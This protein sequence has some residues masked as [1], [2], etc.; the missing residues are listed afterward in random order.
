MLDTDS[1]DSR[2]RVYAAKMAEARRL[3]QELGP[4]LVELAQPG[5]S[6]RMTEQYGGQRRGRALIG[7]DDADDGE[8]EEAQTYGHIPYTIYAYF[9]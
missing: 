2:M 6:T 3:W 4:I 9:H 5:G 8:E 1:G 7:A